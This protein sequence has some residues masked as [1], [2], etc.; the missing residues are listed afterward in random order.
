MSVQE[1]KPQEKKE[2]T[3]SRERDSWY[4][5]NRRLSGLD[6]QEKQCTECIPL[7]HNL[8][9]TDLVAS[10]HSI[11]PV[12][13]PE[14]R[15]LSKGNKIGRNDD[16]L[17]QISAISAQIQCTE[18]RNDGRLVC[19]CCAQK[20]QSQERVEPPRAYSSPTFTL[21]CWELLLL[22]LLPSLTAT[23]SVLENWNSSVWS[24]IPDKIHV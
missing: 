24:V 12:H 2:G 9:L 13:W 6:E 19:T 20:T 16:G 4:L 17:L 18:E 14:R 7:I 1:T 22:L 11:V 8:V 10:F 5:S 23:I 21:C 3:I 15:S